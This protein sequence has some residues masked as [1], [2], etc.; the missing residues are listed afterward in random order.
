MAQQVHTEGSKLSYAINTA[1]RPGLTRD[2]PHGPAD[3]QWVANVVTL[4]YGEHDAILIDTFTLISHN[5]ELV[6]WVKSFK[7]R[8]T[9]IYITHGHVDHWFG[10]GQLLKAFPEAKAVGTS[11]TVADARI[12]DLPV[13]HEMLPGQIPTSVYPEELKDNFI[14]LEGHRLEIINVG[15]TDCAHSTSIWVPDL[16]LIVAGDV[17]YNQT[18]PFTT[19]TTTESRE[20]WAQVNEKLRTFNPIAIIPGHKQPQLI[21]VPEITEA[22]A[23][24]L[25]DFNRIEAEVSTP[26]E[27]Y[28]R[29]L[30][31]YPRW[32]NPGSLW[33][34][35]KL[36]KK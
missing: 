14:D 30:E 18:H 31:L 17:V 12:K 23:K 27:L 5:D 9:H 19:E 3:L 7:R 4:I 16:R 36:A 13:F 28:N 6:E 29:M 1:T 21:D 20:H 22:T 25:R 34:G 32:A 8:L 2:I 35:A 15:H 10:I 26:L 24:Y 33:G 11:D